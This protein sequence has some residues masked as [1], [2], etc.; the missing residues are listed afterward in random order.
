[1][2]NLRLKSR[3]GAPTL[4]DQPPHNLTIATT[5]ASGALFLKNLLLTVEHDERTATVHSIAS[6]PPL[7]VIADELELTGRSKLVGHLP[8]KAS[9]TPND[10]P[11][12]TLPAPLP[13]A[14]H[15]APPLI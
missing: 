6:P 7:R 11:T 15:P 3:S 5:G 9:R 14:P 10:P 1:M 8:G 2:L 12:A 13:T 4:P